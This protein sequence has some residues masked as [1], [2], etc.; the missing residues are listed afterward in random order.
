[1]PGRRKA[2]SPLLKWNHAKNRRMPLRNSIEG[3]YAEK[4]AR[5]AHVR[6][7]S[8]HVPGLHRQLLD[9][10]LDPHLLREDLAISF[11]EIVR[12]SPRLMTSNI[13]CLQR[14]TSQGLQGR[15]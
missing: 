2:D 13:G 10:R 12:L 15:P 11:S 5:F 1:M 14:V 9:D 8:Y 6:S 7:G 4:A 3:S